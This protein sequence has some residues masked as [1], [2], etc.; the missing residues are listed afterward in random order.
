M[1]SST[2]GGSRAAHVRSG[3]E[4]RAG[5]HVRGRPMPPIRHP[6]LGCIRPFS[7]CRP[8]ISENCCNTPGS[9]VSLGAACAV[10]ERHVRG[11]RAVQASSANPMPPKSGTE[12]AA[13]ELTSRSSPSRLLCAGGQ[14]HHATEERRGTG[15]HRVDFSVLPPDS[16]VQADKRPSCCKK[17]GSGG[18]GPTPRGVPCPAPGL[19]FAVCWCTLTHSMQCAC[20]PA[21]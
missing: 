7:P 6:C 3:S 5:V 8:Q 11:S 14:D 10:P 17:P 15:I 13:I 18:L 4:T 21:S 20:G 9:L 19:A 1:A 2:P 12:R 16:C